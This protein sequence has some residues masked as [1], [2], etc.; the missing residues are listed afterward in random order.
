MIE[1][2]NSLTFKQLQILQNI[3]QEPEFNI[4]EHHVECKDLQ[5]VIEETQSIKIEQVTSLHCINI[6]KQE[7]ELEIFDDI[8]L[9]EEQIFNSAAPIE[10]PEEKPT[11]SD[12]K[13]PKKKR[14]KNSAKDN[15]IKVEES[16]QSKG[17]CTQQVSSIIT[18]S[19]ACNNVLTLIHL[20]SRF[21]ETTVKM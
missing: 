15:L 5:A 18:V 13:P 6:I 16:H 2:W 10:L 21:V 20:F 11:V 12:I 3:K 9:D 14:K 17:K 7:P 8:C 1:L 19:R 4:I